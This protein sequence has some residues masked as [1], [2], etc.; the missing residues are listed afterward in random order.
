MNPNY[1]KKAVPIYLAVDCIIFGFDKEQLKLLLFKRKVDPFKGQW[2]LIGNFIKPTESVI[3]SAHR[4]L[5]ETTGLQAV[6]LEELGCYGAINRDAGARVV[7][8]AHYA[9]IRLEAT[10]VQTTQLYEAHWFEI[11]SMPNLILDH[12]D[13]VQNAIK[14]LQR[15]A[16]YE[17]IGFQLLPKKF[18]IPQLKNLYDSIYRK[19]FDRRNFRKKILSM[20]ILEKLDE[21]DK[22][23]SRKGAYLY[24]FK[25]SKTRQQNEREFN[26]RL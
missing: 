3:D 7:S 15:K 19:N 21:K 5:E 18:T 14:E 8:I 16:S 10:H 20:G 1:Y 13:M 9:L 24:Q 25:K 12:Q 17:P 2:S 11:D 22:T 6:Y 4:V 26:L 23:T